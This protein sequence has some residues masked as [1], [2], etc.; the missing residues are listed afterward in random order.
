MDKNPTVIPPN[1]V[2]EQIFYGMISGDQVAIYRTK[3]NGE[4]V[5]NLTAKDL[6]AYNATI[7][8]N[9]QG[10]QLVFPDLAS[11]QR[12]QNS[13]EWHGEFDDVFDELQQRDWL[14]A[15]SVFVH[16]DFHERFGGE[17]ACSQSIP[18]PK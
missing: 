3:V 10:F 8:G 5:F 9:Y 13:E 7:T 16:A 4:W 1:G 17:I 2:I 12:I 6:R 11:Y 15:D 18:I 14:Y